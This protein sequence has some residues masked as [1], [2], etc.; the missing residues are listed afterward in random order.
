MFVDKPF[1]KENLDMY[2]KELAKEFRKNNGN[3]MPAEIILIGGASILINYG[4]REMIYDMDA[5]INSSS[6]MKDA[7]NIVG[8]RL[9]L[10]LGWINT[11]FMNTNS[12]TPRLVGVSKYYKTF[13]NILQIR[14][15]SAE[16]L[17]AM[18]LMA[19]RQYKNDL[20]DIV[21]IIIEQE[22]RGDILTL[23]RI[24]KAII[25]LYDEYELIPYNSR[26]FIEAIY[27]Q[28]NLKDFYRQ[29]REMELDNKDVLVEFQDDYPGELTEDNLENILNVAREKKLK[30]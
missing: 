9:G 7:I 14:T 10:P 4:F 27:K 5:I 8:G 1:T 17:V 15:V 12:Y 24:K 22:E 2:L 29:C 16:Y 13:S 23:E 19:G 20:S 21:G 18:K 30:L 28:S 26:S 11:D 3:K 6:A 25:D